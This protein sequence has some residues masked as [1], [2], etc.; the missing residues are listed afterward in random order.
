MSDPFDFDDPIFGG[1]KAVKDPPR[2]PAPETVVSADHSPPSGV[3]AFDVETGP[4]P[5]DELD[6]LMRHYSP[7]FDDEPPGDFD[8]STVKYGNTKDEAKRREK[9]EAAKAAHEKAV[10]D[11]RANRNRA[12]FQWRQEFIHLAPLSPITG[13]VLA[14]GY[15]DAGG[16]VSI[17]DGPDEATIIDNWLTEFT[18][19]HASGG[20]LVGFHILGFDVP[21]LIRR[22]WKL[23]LDVPPCLRPR[24]LHRNPTLVDLLDVWKCGTR[25]TAWHVD[26]KLDTVARFFGLGGKLDGISGADFHRLWNG[27]PAEREKAVAYLEKDVQLTL[28]IAKAMGVAG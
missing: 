15:C 10:S 6:A 18:D 2:P 3:L 17:D 11:W 14:I 9:L 8:P 22:A 19:A 28:A 27:S 13:R 23:G 4:L 5:Q 16:Q 1:V 21:F 20:R 25:D 26:N 24:E 7:A 12:E